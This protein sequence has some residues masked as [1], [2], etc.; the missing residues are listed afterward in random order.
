M[1]SAPPSTAVDAVLGGGR[2]LIEASAGSGKTRAITTLVARLL[3]EQDLAIERILV[4]TFTKAATAELRERV[5]RLLRHIQ[6]ALTDPTAGADPQARELLTRWAHDKTLDTTQIQARIASALL[7]IDRAN[8]LT[9]HGFCQRVLAEFA[10]E[11]GF[12]FG[13]DISGDG[14]GIVESVVR[15]IWQR[16]FRDCSRLFAHHLVAREFLPTEL[17][18]WFGSLRTKRFAEIRGVAA[19]PIP[20]EDAEQ[21]CHDTLQSVLEVWQAHGEAYCEFMRDNDVLNKNSYGPA[22]VEVSLDQIK[23][24]LAAGELPAN[25]DG[26]QKLAAELGGRRAASKCKKNRQL[27]NNP[28]FAAF[29]RLADAGAELLA[30][31][32]GWLR[33]VRRQLLSEAAGDIQRIIRRERRLAYD[34][35]IMELNHGL[36]SETGERLAASLR[37]QFPVALIDEFQDTDPTQEQIFS[38]IYGSAENPGTAKPAGLP[39]RQSALY[40]VGD[41]KQSIYQFR[42]ADIF[43]YL[44]AQQGSDCKLQLGRNWRSAPALVAAVNSLFD[45]PL[46]FTVPEISFTP[47]MPGREPEAQLIIEGEDSPPLTFWLPQDQ[48]SNDA[49]N[50]VVVDETANDIARL[51]NL[52]RQGKA[53]LGGQ[54]LRASDIAVLVATRAQGHDIAAALRRRG[55]RSVETA[56]TGVFETREAEQL[57]RLLLAIAH[58]ARQDYRRTA[59]TGDLFDLDNEQLL[60]L[61]ENDESWN[62]WTERIARWH[63]NWHSTGIGATLRAIIK[64]GEGA[65]SLLRYSDGPRRLTNLYHLTELLHEAEVENRF[66]PAG[67]LAWFNRR[68]EGQA[69]AMAG[70]EDALTLR[71]DSDEELVRILTIHGSKGLEFPIVYLPFAWYGKSTS[72][73]GIKQIHQTSVSYHVRRESL[74]P[75]VLDL[76]PD[77]SSQSMRTL[78]AFGESVR[79]LY[80]ALTRAR[81]R[82]TIAWTRITTNSRNKELPPLA[83]LMHRSQQHNEL[84]GQISSNGELPS[85]SAAVPEAVAGVHDSLRAEFAETSQKSRDDFQADVATVAGRCPGIKIREL[86]DQPLA[87]NKQCVD[88]PETPLTCR[89]FNRTLRSVRQLTSFSG[90]TADHAASAPQQTRMEPTA[91]DYDETEGKQLTPADTTEAETGEKNR[92]LNVF[93]FPR[94]MHVGSCLHRIFEILDAEPERDI[95]AVCG[96]QLARAGIEPKWQETACSM[97]ANTLD[98]ELQEPEQSRFRLADIDQRLTELEFCYP[99]KALHCADLEQLLERFGYPGLLDAGQD[100]QAITGYLRGFIDLT[101][102]HQGRWYILDY[103]SNWL[104]SQAADYEPAQLGKTMREHRYQLQYLIY[105]VALHRYLGT[106]L[107]DYDYQRHIGGAFYLFLRGMAPAAGMSRGVWFDRPPKECIAALDQFMQGDR[108]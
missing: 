29:D 105:L 18:N 6:D 98:T 15:D 44:S 100:I 91:S 81:E 78:E 70:Q 92:Q 71:L 51:L 104:G 22:K 42:G 57:R 52:A 1:T 2:T 45:I 68:I 49:A 90:L 34:D 83:W 36:E 102:A 108:P 37:R 76:A 65:G 32:D 11:T 103:K 99:V 20:P 101:F 69:V 88:E 24:L 59:L 87:S 94:G 55:C 95:A 27:P 10:F 75:A 21:A 54:A 16:K 77:A 63:D 30:N 33:H 4:V 89:Q 28:M 62:R 107:P 41:P 58:P 19:V 39:A 46:A 73:P 84:L 106:R 35:L 8:I 53:R 56:D 93:N 86:G 85:P 7:D 48:S 17:A 31:F 60:A 13:F 5:R 50:S 12:P 74:F 72:T 67:L 23:G 14:A 97:V 26:L 82:C 64:T 40:I 79:L 43:A 9:I 38:R 3:V 61:G 66:S 96:E 47:V 80:V 25:V